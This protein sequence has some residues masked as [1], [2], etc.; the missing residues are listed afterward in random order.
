MQ[1]K[2]WS[3][4]VQPV[5]SHFHIKHQQG[6]FT[7]RLI[8]SGLNAWW[9]WSSSTAAVLFRTP[10]SLTK[11]NL[12]VLQILSRGWDPSTAWME[13]WLHGWM[14]FLHGNN[15]APEAAFLLFSTGNHLLH[16]SFPSLSLSLLPAAPSSLTMTTRCPTRR[17]CWLPKCTRV[18]SRTSWT[19]CWTATTTNSDPTSEVGPHFSQ[20]IRSV[21]EA[22]SHTPTSAVGFAAKHVC[23]MSTHVFFFFFWIGTLDRPEPV[24]VSFR[25]ERLSTIA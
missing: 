16:P 14:E 25:G 6:L 13:G 20:L 4:R 22:Q 19:A 24:I 2:I 3:E 21:A 7:L 12:V 18:T 10:Q 11:I 8:C 5:S 15:T 23:A 17:G 9:G 1:A